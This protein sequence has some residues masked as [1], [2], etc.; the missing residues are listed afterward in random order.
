LDVSES[1]GAGDGEVG[2]TVSPTGGDKTAVPS[3]IPSQIVTTT[4]TS[5]K[6]D[7]PDDDD[8]DVED[9]DAVSSQSPAAAVPMPLMVK[10]ITSGSN[11]A[12][13]AP[14]AVPTTT[15]GGT[16]MSLL[17]ERH[18]CQTP[19][20]FQAWLERVLAVSSSSPSLAANDSSAVGRIPLDAGVVKAVWEAVSATT[21]RAKTV[22]NGPE[23]ESDGHD[24]VDDN[25]DDGGQDNGNDRSNKKKMHT[26]DNSATEDE[27]EEGEVRSLTT[28]TTNHKQSATA[29]LSSSSS[30]P[31][32][33]FDE[34]K[35]RKKQRK[36]QKQLAGVV[37]QQEQV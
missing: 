26:D 13:F 7:R 1:G 24:D 4:T 11:A 30:L 23:V 18:Q 25:D 34:W 2:G 32:N 12:A 35:E 28:T 21:P 5:G 9:D 14:E 10:T 16:W 6:R 20:Q 29:E 27:E 31:K 19:T 33:K 8:D 36:L 22:A 15:D 3:S 17:K 37:S